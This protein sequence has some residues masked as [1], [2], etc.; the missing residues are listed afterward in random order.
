MATATVIKPKPKMVPT[1]SIKGYRPD[2]D[3]F[4]GAPEKRN[5]PTG[6]A[7]QTRALAAMEPT[8]RP[9]PARRS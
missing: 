7:L 5:P 8:R 1:S 4:V 2:W 9:R 6:F 3:G